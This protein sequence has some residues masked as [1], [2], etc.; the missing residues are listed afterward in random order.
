MICAFTVYEVAL[1]SKPYRPPRV[2]QLTE[3]SPIYSGPPNAENMLSLVTDGPR[4]YTTVLAKGLTEIA[5]ID[6]SGTQIQVVSL[7]DELT[8]ISIADISRDGSRLIVRS[9]RSR[10]S[11]QPLWIVPTA[12]FSASRVGEVLA[13]DATWM[14][15]GNRVLYA[16]GNEL[17]VVQLDTGSVTIYARLPGRAFWPRW[18]PDGNTLRFTLLNPV[19]HMSSLWELNAAKRH[20]Q[21]LPFPDLK[22][23]SLCCGSWT[24]DSST[25][26][27][28]ASNKQESNLWAVGTGPNP[29]LKQLTNGPLRYVSP[30]PARGDKTLY[31]V[32]L[33]Q[34]ASVQIYD[35][36]SHRF[37]AAPS[38]LAQAIRIS[39]SRDGKWVAWTDTSGRLWRA[40]S[41]DGSARLRLTGD[42]LEVFMTQWSPDDQQLIMMARKPGATWQIY[43]VSAMTGG[44]SRLVLADQRNLADPGWS[45]DGGQ[46]VFGREADLMGKESGPH[47]IEILDLA[48]HRTR[49]LPH[50]EDFFSP[51]WSPDGRWISALSL[52]QTRLLLYDVQHSSW[53]TLFTGSAADPVWSADSQAVYFHD[54]AEPNP[55]ILRVTIDGVSKPV[56]DLS[57]LGLPMVADDFFSGVTPNGSPIIEPRIGTGNLYS[58]VLPPTNSRHF[59]H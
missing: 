26:V 19:T 59:W 27:F 5:S 33:E 40:R 23:M 18:S 16:S 45:A 17:G 1:P 57:K 8:P 7:P 47:D 30:L 55:A 4:I 21:R 12:G 15:T 53:R 29:Q 56:V 42:D 31:A 25:Y 46:I 22:D 14:P 37:M 50:S 52:D 35:Q 49:T 39:Y 38:F 34:P 2:E 6:L 41:S 58:I 32:G 9:R 3:S 20:P 28:Q 10:E 43:E 11:E 36:P 54:F 48:T 51:R 13:H 24:A 44:D